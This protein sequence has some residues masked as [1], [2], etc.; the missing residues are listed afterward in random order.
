M[1][2][3]NLTF[4]KE[5]EACIVDHNWEIL[6]SIW[7][8]SSF[9]FI[10]NILQE[11]FSQRIDD[12]VKR[13]SPEEL[14]HQIEIKNPVPFSDIEIWTEQII[15]DL[16][17][18]NEIEEIRKYMQL[19]LTPV[20][21]NNFEAIPSIWDKEAH[22]R[23][24][25]DSMIDK[26]GPEEWLKI[27]KSFAT[28]SDQTNIWWLFDWLEWSITDEQFQELSRRFLNIITEMKD[29]LLS[30]NWKV[31][32]WEG[33]TRQDI[34]NDVLTKLKWGNFEDKKQILI[35]PHFSTRQEMLNWIWKHNW[36]KKNID[37]LNI[38][39]LWEKDMHSFLAK[40]KWESFPWV[41]IR[42][43]DASPDFESSTSVTNKI[44]EKLLEIREEFLEEIKL[45][46][47]A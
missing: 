33:K 22:Q 37:W 12:L 41:E 43:I 45:K 2:N 30:Q 44:V 11:R 35:P 27:V 26:F 17:M 34:A 47:A 38:W 23:K 16:R 1:K 42:A 5:I 46:V 21:K 3:N 29:L 15:W 8:E 20:S 18:I 10:E 25:F 19:I 13:I 14:W 36:I 40:I 7:N 24:L 4:W 6:P 32:N 28:F 39:Q 9:E 31:V